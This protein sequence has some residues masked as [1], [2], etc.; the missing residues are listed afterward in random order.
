MQKRITKYDFDMKVGETKVY[1]CEGE[2]RYRL[3]RSLVNSARAKNIFLNAEVVEDGIQYTR[4][5]KTNKK[6]A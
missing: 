5:R 1:P 3:L 4:V 6:A 2:I